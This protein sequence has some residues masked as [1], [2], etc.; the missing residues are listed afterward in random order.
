M[1][2]GLRILEVPA[3]LGGAQRVHR[4]LCVLNQQRGLLF[5]G[6]LAVISDGRDGQ[7]VGTGGIVELHVR[8]LFGRLEKLV[9]FA[10]R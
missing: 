6:Q 1:A 9:E 8:Q 4:Q 2:P 10:D 3:R 7:R 5:G